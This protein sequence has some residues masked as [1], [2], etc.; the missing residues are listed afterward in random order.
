MAGL[1]Q[2]NVAIAL[3]RPDEAT[4][5]DFENPG[6]KSHKRDIQQAAISAQIGK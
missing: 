1:A 4:L 3:M 2:I 5:F 6:I